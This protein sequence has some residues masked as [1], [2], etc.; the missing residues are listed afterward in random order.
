MKIFAIH[1]ID[2]FAIQNFWAHT[3]NTS[4]QSRSALF[5]GKTDISISKFVFDVSRKKIDVHLSLSDWESLNTKH[6]ANLKS[7]NE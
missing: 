3:H 5:I 1:R 2:Y 4:F 7:N 6:V